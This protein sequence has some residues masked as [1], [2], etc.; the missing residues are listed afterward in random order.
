MIYVFGGLQQK[1]E[2]FDVE[3]I[4]IK[5]KTTESTAYSWREQVEF[6]VGRYPL[7]QE[8]EEVI[9]IEH[10]YEGNLQGISE[11]QEKEELQLEEIK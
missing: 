2:L 11:E 9:Q 6:S 5:K 8:M 4:D 1:G 10:K 3:K 7:I